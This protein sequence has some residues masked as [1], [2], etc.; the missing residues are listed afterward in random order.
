[1]LKY[2]YLVINSEISIKYLL[3]IYFTNTYEYKYICAT[4]VHKYILIDTINLY[5][6]V[7]E[8]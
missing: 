7:F 3:L 5:L 8:F 6:D 2:F 1:M 4:V